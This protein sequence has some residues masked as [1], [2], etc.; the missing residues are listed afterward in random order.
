VHWCYS[1]FLWQ[2]RWIQLHSPSRAL[3]RA[4]RVVWRRQFGVGLNDAL[5]MGWRRV[6]GPKFLPV[7]WGNR[8]KRRLPTDSRDGESEQ[9]YDCWRR[10]GDDGGVVVGEGNDVEVLGAGLLGGH[11]SRVKLPDLPPDLRCATV[12]PCDRTRPVFVSVG[13]RRG[14]LPWV[15]T[16]MVRRRRRI[17]G[18]SGDHAELAGGGEVRKKEDGETRRG[19]CNEART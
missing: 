6:C 9:G 15:A 17:V 10:P 11:T 14:N 8:T 19:R 18:A 1:D 2:A 4:T 3:S 12:S 13:A 5:P 7:I 16:A